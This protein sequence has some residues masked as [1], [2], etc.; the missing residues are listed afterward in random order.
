M[1]TAQEALRIILSEKIPERFEK[2]PLDQS[3]GRCLAEDVYADI[4]QPPFDRVAMDG[5]AIRKA[6]LRPGVCFNII[7]IIA[8]GSPSKDLPEGDVCFEIMT[9]AVLPSG[10]DFVIRYEDL[11]ISEGKAEVSS[12]LSSLTPNF[13]KKGSDYSSGTR[14]LN[15][16]TFIKSTTTAILASVGHAEVTVIA[17]PKVAILS[18]G[19]ELVSI[20][21]MPAPHQ[22]RWSNGVSLKQ[23]LLAFKQSEVSIFKVIDDEDVLRQ[24]MKKLLN[25][26]DVLLLTGGVSAG[27]FDFVPGILKECKVDEIFHKVAQ[28]P[29]KPLWFGK[30]HSGKYVFGL[31]GNPVSCLVNLRKFVIPFLSQG[32]IQTA[33]K[34]ALSEDV[35]FNKSLAY[36]CL[37]KVHFEEGRILAS[38]LPGNG[39]GDFFQ[40]RDSDGFIELRPE[41]GPFKK[42]FV[43]ELYLWGNQCQ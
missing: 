34:A 6:Q 12:D 43:S 35:K 32:R 29:G 9:G 13:H 4:D 11:K 28:R 33:I 8:A 16:G 41:E 19:D 31:P 25:E 15:A 18:T 37:V 2:I 40:L 5:I 22:I 17:C 42:G 3:I 39:S 21:E 14:V 24:T 7:G 1:I 30:T 23:E 26:Y 27:K 10:A 38:P 20:D 36:Y